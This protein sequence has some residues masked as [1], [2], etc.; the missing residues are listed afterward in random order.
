MCGNTRCGGHSSSLFICSRQSSRGCAE[1]APISTIRS[2]S[3]P[4][5]PH[6][7]SAP[8]REPRALS[9]RVSPLYSAVPF[10]S[11]EFVRHAGPTAVGEQKGRRWVRKRLTSLRV[12]EAQAFRTCKRCKRLSTTST[13]ISVLCA[14]R[15]ASRGLQRRARSAGHNAKQLLDLGSGRMQLLAL[16]ELVRVR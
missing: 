8:H 3:R 15:W 9:P 16:E 1:V 11:L 4:V 14:M 5:L 10:E 12:V 2:R 13:R 7:V 6:P